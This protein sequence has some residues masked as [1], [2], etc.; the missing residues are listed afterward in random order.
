MLK[1]IYTSMYLGNQLKSQ[2]KN[3][4]FSQSM[5]GSKIIPEEIIIE[6]EKENKENKEN[7][8]NKIVIKKI[9]R[10]ASKTSSEFL[11]ELTDDDKISFVI[12]DPKFGMFTLFKYHFKFGNHYKLTKNHQTIYCSHVFSLWLAIPILVFIS[13]WLIYTTLIVNQIETY[14]EGLC[15]NQANAQEKLL[16]FAV[17]LL[18]FCK[19][20]FLWDNL[21]SRSKK[22]FVI[23]TDSVCTVID[24]L[25]E[26]GFNIL[27]YFTNLVI[28]YT[29]PDFMNMLMNCLAME[30]L[31]LIDNEFEETYFKYQPEVALDIFDKLF[32]SY[33][34]NKNYVIDRMERD[35]CFRFFKYITWIPHKLIVLSHMLLPIICF[36]MVL[37]GPICK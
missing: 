8:D 1:C 20:F 37:Y 35:C 10:I 21:L 6:N 29:E 36:F 17:A 33:N 27:V 34:E 28:I 30:F 31:M 22:R 23:K 18:Y 3:N 14:K 26:F 24:A 25:Q 12:Q 11:G 2:I 4:L 32:V 19:S 9:S 5:M 15:P 7:Q 16:M 13:Q